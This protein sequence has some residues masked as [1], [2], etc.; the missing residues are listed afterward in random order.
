MTLQLEAILF[1]DFC[2]LGHNAG[3]SEEHGASVFREKKIGKA[4]P[5]ALTLVFCLAYST[6]LKM[7]ATCSFET[8]VD[9]Q[10]T[11]RLYTQKIER[12]FIATAIR[13]S[14]PTISSRVS[15]IRIYITVTDK[16][17]TD[18]PQGHVTESS[19]SSSAFY[20]APCLCVS[21]IERHC[22]TENSNYPR[23]AGSV[24]A[25]KDVGRTELPM[26]HSQCH[27]RSTYT[28]STIKEARRHSECF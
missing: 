5:P 20:K 3:V 7:E 10:R 6:T 4:L 26:V 12:I 21:C 2:L 14:N 19:W 9:F 13:T 17:A 24:H 16:V 1:E 15:F 18:S 28:A 22:S 27:D 23:H 8:S 11:T 25:Y